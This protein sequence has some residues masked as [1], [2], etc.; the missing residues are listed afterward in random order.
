MDNPVSSAKIT[1]CGVKPGSAALIHNTDSPPQRRTRP[2]FTADG[3]SPSAAGGPALQTGL[4]SSSQRTGCAVH[5]PSSMIFGKHKKTKAEAG[6]IKTCP[7]AKL[8]F[9]VC[10]NVIQSAA[11]RPDHVNVLQS[12]ERQQLSC[13]SLFYPPTA[14]S[15]TPNDRFTGKINS[16]EGKP[17]SKQTVASYLLQSQIFANRVQIYMRKRSVHTW[18]QKHP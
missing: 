7:C 9:D 5:L 8:Q 17:N 2:G 10:R 6:Q 12:S 13:S 15:S 14:T 16:Q 4:Q 11:T 3:L 1:S 18:Q